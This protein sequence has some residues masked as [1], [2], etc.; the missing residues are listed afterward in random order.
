MELQAI[1]YSAMVAKMTF[2]QA[3]DAHRKYL[4]SVGRGGENPQSNIL[5]FLEWDEPTEELFATDVRIILAS[6][7]FSR[8]LATAVLWLNEYGIDIRCVR[9]Q[10]Y[11][12]EG[13]LL[14]DVQQVLPLPE[15][16]DYTIKVREKVVHTRER[17]EGGPD[18]TRFDMTLDGAVTTGLWKR[19]L[20][21]GVVQHV[22]AKYAITPARLAEFC[23]PHARLWA[24]VDTQVQSEETF[25]EAAAAGFEAVGKSFDPRRY[26]TEDEDLIRSGGKTYALVN[27]WGGGLWRRAIQAIR[28]NVPGISI[29]YQPT[30]E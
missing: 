27:Q 23:P 24:I 1:R 21:L 17:R 10:P 16:E 8:E 2:E 15:A 29:E 20:I 12:I 18:F 7:E 26:F 25:I 19:R 3:V 13:R 22:V 11:R 14:I 9:M 28:D 5:S 30:G 4:A 6:A